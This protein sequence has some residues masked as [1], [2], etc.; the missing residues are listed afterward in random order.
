MAQ[1][2]GMNSVQMGIGTAATRFKRVR[3]DFYPDALP[4]RCVGVLSSASQ[5]AQSLYLHDFHA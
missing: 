5:S 3:L 1:G 4:V 2:D